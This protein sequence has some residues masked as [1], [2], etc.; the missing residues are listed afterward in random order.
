VNA[1]EKHIIV[2][3]VVAA[4]VAVVVGG[5]TD[6]CER[7]VDGGMTDTCEK[8]A[9]KKDVC[10]AGLMCSLAKNTINIRESQSPKNTYLST[11]QI[12]MRF[13]AYKRIFCWPHFSKKIVAIAKYCSLKNPYKKIIM[14]FLIDFYW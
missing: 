11:L 8:V 9:G 1:A 4:V 5:M 7:S 12:L 6:T 10:V 13:A 2:V 3:V 14:Q